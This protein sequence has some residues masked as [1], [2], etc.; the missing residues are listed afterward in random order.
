MKQLITL[1]STEGK[2]NEQIAKE[3]IKNINKF[4]EKKQKEIEKNLNK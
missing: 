4:K 3:M 2:T 1:V